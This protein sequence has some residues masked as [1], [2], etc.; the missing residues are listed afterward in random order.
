MCVQHFTRGQ[1]GLAQEW[2]GTVWLNPPY[3]NLRPW[4]AKAYEYA[5][6]G[7]T[8][9]A[10]LPSWTDA[11]WFHDFVGFGRVTFIRGKLAYGG[12][13]GFAPFA[14]MIVEWNPETVKRQ[15]GAPLDAVLDS[16]IAVSGSYKPGACN[17]SGRTS[18]S[19]HAVTNR[20]IPTRK[21][22][23]QASERSLSPI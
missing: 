13:S 23:R 10:L 6:S 7:G 22:A 2:Y 19:D 4:C 17:R 11:S 5:K 9:I 3:A 15:S 21:L 14:S 16:G 8:V 20:S 12:R 1:D 18:D